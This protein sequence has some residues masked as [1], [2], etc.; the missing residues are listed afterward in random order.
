MKIS[1][2][3]PRIFAVESGQAPAVRSESLKQRAG[4]NLKREKAWIAIGTA[5]I[6]SGCGA[7]VAPSV[8]TLGGGYTP[9][10]LSE[11]GGDVARWSDRS[12]TVSATAGSESLSDGDLQALMQEA[13]RRWNASQSEVSVSVVTGPSAL[14]NLTFAPPS[15]PDLSGRIVGVT[16]RTFRFQSPVS[17]M[18]SAEIKIETGLRDEARL[19]VIAHELGHALGI[20]GHSSDGDDLM[21]A[22]PAPGTQPTQDDANTL[23]SIYAA[24]S[25]KPGRATGEV[26]RATT[27]CGR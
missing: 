20:G 9:N 16:T 4:Y 3:R 19:A 26:V 7:G 17:K 15:D 8:G 24:R 12:V 21:Y 25:V 2:R 13:A 23:R 14:I 22:A 11:L 10:Y 18:L 6:L 5:A 1:H 27:A